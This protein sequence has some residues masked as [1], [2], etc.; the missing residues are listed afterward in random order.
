MQCNLCEDNV[1]CALLPCGHGACEECLQA[2]LMSGE[3]CLVCGLGFAKDRITKLDAVVTETLDEE[4]RKSLR[5]RLLADTQ[6]FE[7]HRLKL[8]ARA[9]TGAA[10]EAHE[11]A[12]IH[13]DIDRKKAGLEK[14]RTT[15]TGTVRKLT[16]ARDKL[17]EHA[18]QTVAVTYA[19]PDIPPAHCEVIMPPT[20][21][22]DLWRIDPRGID[23]KRCYLTVADTPA[24]HVITV[25]I[26]D[27]MGTPM[28]YDAI[29]SIENG[30]GIKA[31]ISKGDWIVSVPKHV[32]HDAF[33]VV[34][35]PRNEAVFTLHTPLHNASEVLLRD[36]PIENLAPDA[37][38]F[39]ASMCGTFLA[40]ITKHVLLVWRYDT[41]ANKYA[42]V[43]AKEY[44]RVLS[45]VF[46]CGRGIDGWLTVTVVFRS[47]APVEQESFCEEHALVGDERAEPG[48]PHLPGMV[49]VGWCDAI[50]QCEQLGSGEVQIWCGDYMRK[51]LN[52]QA[53]TTDGHTFFMH[54]PEAAYMDAGSLKCAY[55]QP[56]ERAV[57]CKKSVFRLTEG[58]VARDTRS[59]NVAPP[60]TI[61]SSMLHLFLLYFE[62]DLTAR[63][64][65]YYVA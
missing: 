37:T 38:Q 46:F 57:S 12:R 33:P 40:A 41:D 6:R 45:G 61:A 49:Y 23:P 5:A 58:A 48:K 19:L 43:M 18:E 27:D 4:T 59:L 24:D 64:Q 13:A 56:C 32:A 1:A 9:A 28:P 3:T 30:D 2:L 21:K 65:M 50:A 47:A 55:V 14:L 20:R 34:V 16:E 39:T 52:V 22:P 42:Q 8:A 25:H 15:M 63:V 53:L 26:R 29:T 36:V 62:P 35:H 51:Y 60:F 31:G 10:A 17:Q 54:H 44:E 11:I 7:N